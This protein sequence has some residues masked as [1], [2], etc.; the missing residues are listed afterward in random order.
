MRLSSVLVGSSL[1]LRRGGSIVQRL[2]RGDLERGWYRVRQ[3]GPFFFNGVTCWY[4]VP[5]A[6]AMLSSKSVRVMT[7]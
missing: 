5:F 6:D 3:S 1:P 7:S 4:R 2:R